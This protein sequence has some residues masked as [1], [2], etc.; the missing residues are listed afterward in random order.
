MPPVVWWY[1]PVCGGIACCVVVLPVVRSSAWPPYPS[2]PTPISSLLAARGPEERRDQHPQLTHPAHPPH[3]APTPPFCTPSRLQP[4][5][6]KSGMI[7]IRADDDQE[8]EDVL[9]Q[10]SLE[11]RVRSHTLVIV[12]VWGGKEEGCGR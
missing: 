11:Q 7:N 4:L 2:T 5:D 8:P 9:A 3:H 6:Q 1:C 10:F 12:C